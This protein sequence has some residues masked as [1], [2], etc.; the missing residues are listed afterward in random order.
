[1]P[2]AR[3]EVVGLQLLHTKGLPFEHRTSDCST[4]LF[5]HCLHCQPLKEEISLTVTRELQKKVDVSRNMAS[6]RKRV[7]GVFNYSPP[8]LNSAR[9]GVPIV[10]MMLAYSVRGGKSMIVSI[11]GTCWATNPTPVPGLQVGEGAEGHLVR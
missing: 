11:T 5:S 8:D 10:L 7:F 1:M 3:G 2:L 9:T 4:A 6:L